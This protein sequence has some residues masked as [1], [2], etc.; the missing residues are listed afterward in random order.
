MDVVVTGGIGTGKST[1]AK[2][3]AQRGGVHL[4]ADAIVRELQQPGGELFEAMV[5]HFGE[6]V[7]APDGN[8]NRQAIADIVFADKEQLDKLGDLVHP[9]VRREMMARR[10]ALR[11]SGKVVISEVPLLVEGRLKQA[12]QDNSSGAT[13]DFDF[14]VVVI[15]DQQTALARLEQRGMSR[16]DAQARMANQ[17]SNEQRQAI[18]DFVIDNS[19]DLDELQPAIDECWARITELAADQPTDQPASQS[20]PSN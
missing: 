17:A 18:A 7:L 14:V 6:D 11:D 2:A 3:L 12:E 20:T 13:P 19:G 16:Q 15:A 5:E 1:V 8:L 4:D 9:A 10:Q